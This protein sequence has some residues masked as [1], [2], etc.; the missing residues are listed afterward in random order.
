MPR[1]MGENPTFSRQAYVIYPAQSC[2]DRRKNQF[3]TLGRGPN[4]SLS[5]TVI[6]NPDAG[7]HHARPT[8]PDLRMAK[9][10]AY[11]TRGLAILIRRLAL[12]AWLVTCGLLAAGPDVEKIIT[13]AAQR[14]GRPG[15][16]TM[17][18]WRD[19][20]I[21]LHDGS[22]ASKVRRVND[23]INRHI[24]FADDLEVW[25]V[26]DYWATPLESLGR[27]AGDCEDFAIAKYVTLR[28]LGIPNERLRLIYVRARIGGPHSGISQAHMVLGYYPAADAEP[29]V[30]DSLTSDIR[31]SAER[32]DLT[33]LFSFNDEGIWADG[34]PAA[35]RTE[36]ASARLSRWRDVLARMRAE[37]FT[38][39]NE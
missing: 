6:N 12:A 20:L 17:L 33:P 32:P 2:N 38:F 10:G 34:A 35:N 15:Q 37:G 36:K 5:A 31:T 16:N 21:S 9:P 22:E 11:P 25:G 8:D 27:S 26:E 7:Q 24:R 28:I 39:P 18:R 3:K 23:F 4:I 29:M 14:Y 30:L 1:Q 19:L 13:L